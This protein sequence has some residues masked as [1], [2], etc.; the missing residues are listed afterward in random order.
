MAIFNSYVNL[1]E[2]IC[3]VPVIDNRGLVD[4]GVSNME[5][6]HEV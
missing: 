5:T 3:V 6:V 4:V 2:G 1:P